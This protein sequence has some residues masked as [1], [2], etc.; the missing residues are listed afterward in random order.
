MVWERR[1]H[2]EL[3]AD[4]DILLSDLCQ[5]WDF[6]AGVTAKQLLAG[7]KPL[8]SKKFTDTVIL[9]EGMALADETNWIRRIK[10]KFVQRYGHEV[11]IRDYQ[12]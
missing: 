9:T 3:E 1:R 2:P 7:G 8:T 11:S 5:E 12:I 6:C 10:R 4:L